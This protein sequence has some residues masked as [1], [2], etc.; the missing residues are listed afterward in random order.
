MTK[1][2]DGLPVLGYQPQTNDKVGAVNENKL[3]EEQVLRMLD[4]LEQVPE[5]DQ[6]WLKIGRT[7]IEQGFMAMNRAVFQPKRIDTI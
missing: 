6:H 1:E 4:Q 5:Y 2:L 3:L 7:A